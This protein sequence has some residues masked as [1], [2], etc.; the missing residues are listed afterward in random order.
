MIIDFHCHTFPE[1]I[2]AYALRHMQAMSHNAVFTDGTAVALKQSMADSGVTYSVVLPVVTNPEKASHINDVSI[3]STGTDGLIYFGGIHPECESYHAELSRICDAGLKGIKLHPLQ[4]A[5]NID[6]PRYLRILERCGELGLI[7]VLHAGAD[8]GFPG[9]DRCTPK[10]IR[11]ALDQVGPVQLV[12]A[13]MGSLMHWDTVPEY[14]L[15]TGVYIDTSFALGTMAQTEEHF[16]TEE[17]LQLLT[18][19][20]FCSLVKIFGKER[21]LFG[22]DSPWNR[23]VYAR[24]Q[25]EA[26]PLDEETM[27]HIFYKNA[28]RLLQLADGQGV[29][30]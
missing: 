16:Y 11:S 25:I 13:H 28:C 6:D 19:E 24:R 12:A 23:Q 5:T 4:Q 10:M 17:Q 26:L 27:A 20:Q 30:A 18:E 29:Q 15:D 3:A 7:V 9:E 1:K 21:V 22:T 8:P 2:A 14:L